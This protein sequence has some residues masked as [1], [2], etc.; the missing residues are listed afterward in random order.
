LNSLPLF[1]EKK[2]DNKKLLFDLE[3]K[4][5]N[6]AVEGIR[7]LFKSLNLN[8]ISADIKKTCKITLAGFL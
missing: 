1:L 6:L 4:M 7:F 3:S 8:L 2:S 5:E